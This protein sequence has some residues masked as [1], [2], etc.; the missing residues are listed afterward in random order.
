MR[1]YRWHSTSV[2]ISSRRPRTCPGHRPARCT[3]VSSAGPGSRRK[4]SSE[5]Q[6][7]CRPNEAGTGVTRPD[8]LASRPIRPACRE[9]TPKRSLVR[10]QCRGSSPAHPL[11]CPYA[12]PQTAS[13]S[14][15]INTCVNVLIIAGN[16]S[17]DA[18]SI[19]SH[20]SSTGFIHLRC[21]HRASLSF[22]GFSRLEGSCGGRLSSTQHTRHGQVVKQFRATCAGA[23]C[24]PGRE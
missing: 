15:D 9:F 4:Y 21:A 1:L 12:A 22:V 24:T 8:D 13:A 7:R 16:T 11:R 18:P 6:Q 17:G 23:W 19:C 20:S 5:V 10:S 3:A 2:P 14:A